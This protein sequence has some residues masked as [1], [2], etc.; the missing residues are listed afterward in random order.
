MAFTF[1]GP[2]RWSAV[3]D[4][5]GY[6]TYTLISRVTSDTALDGPALAMQTPGLPI[7]GAT[8]LLDNDIDVWA[9][10]RWDTTVEP[11]LE[12]EPNKHFN[13]TNV[14]STRP[15]GTGGGSAPGGMS[16]GR[17][18]GGP[19]GSPNDN[20]RSGCRDFQFEDPLTEPPKI[21][22]SFVKYSEFAAFDKDA[23]GLF[24]SNLE[25][26]LGAEAEFD[27]TRYT[28]RIEFNSPILNLTFINGFRD[29]VNSQALWGFP[30]RCVKLTNHTWERR[31]Y[32]SCYVYYVHTFD[33]E[34]RVNNGAYSNLYASGWDRLI[35]N[36]GQ[37]MLAGEYAP[38]ASK[39]YGG[40][41]C[42]VEI[43]AVNAVTGA[44]TAMNIAPTAGGT[45]YPTLASV[46]LA[47]NSANGQFGVV[48]GGTD[49][50]GVVTSISVG[51][52]LYAGINYIAAAGLATYPGVSYKLNISSGDFPDPT[53]SMDF[54]RARDRYAE[55]CVAPLN[56][57]GVPLARGEPPTFTAIQYY[58]EA[59]F[60][61]LGIP[62]ILEI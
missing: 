55:L 14:F 21:G 23:N 25:P 48:I 24:Y 19:G 44:I 62:A 57:A 54:V 58:K 26:I 18:G 34:I 46:P 59:D 42:T 1:T 53:C 51:T 60:L 35:G 15:P 31:F 16:G 3:R 4:S 27:A 28:V 29:K 22:G 37:K 47:I 49:A 45:G 39:I 52:F 8:W 56:K 13:V 17:G 30:A 50:N 5:E 6:R 11:L 38:N 9:W 7:P 20:K 33:F 32:G 12:G 43:T 61:Q 41:G 36:A 10:C 2:R 40:S